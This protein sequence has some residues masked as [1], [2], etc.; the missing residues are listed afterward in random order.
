[1]SPFFNNKQNTHS[2]EYNT[3]SGTGCPESGFLNAEP[4]S[5]HLKTEF[6]GLC[7]HVFQSLP[8]T[9]AAIIEM[10][11]TG[12]PHGTTVVADEQTEG[13]GRGSRKW[14]S[15]P[16]VNLYLS[17]LV[18]PPIPP[19]KAP[20]I[21]LAWAVA[22]A[23]TL[24]QES[25]LT[26][27]LKWPND[28]TVE[29]KKLCGILTE[30]NAVSQRTDWIVAGIGINVNILDFPNELQATSTSLRICTGRSHSREILASV[31]LEKMEYWYGVLLRN[32]P[33]EIL[34][35]W[36]SRPNILG[37]TVTIKTHKGPIEGLAVN[38]DIDGALL[39][40]T[41]NGGIERILSGDLVVPV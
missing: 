21:T 7:L 4:I 14:H 22:A 6:F 13:R 1:M 32:G 23:E 16:G 31:L 26:P 35:T 36:K 20:P 38:L 24:E 15:P 25:G 37:Q 18:R 29:N 39:L 11:K 30:I 41:K 10:A 27:T 28:L 9:N 33:V 17:V 8:S 40:K 2:N 34:E 19:D 5:R 3:R 12:A